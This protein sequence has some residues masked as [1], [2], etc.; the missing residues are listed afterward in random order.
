MVSTHFWLL[1]SP[2]PG[3]LAVRCVQAWLS[4]GGQEVLPLNE[5]A[6]IDC[7]YGICKAL[8]Y[9]HSQGFVHGEGP[10]AAASVTCCRL[11]LE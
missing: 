3:G 5:A 11:P 9:L 10:L 4:G 1:N 7:L 6:R 2:N 8:E